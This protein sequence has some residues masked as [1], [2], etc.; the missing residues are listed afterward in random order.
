MK[1]ILL[2]SALIVA[3]VFSACEQS[4]NP[5]DTQTTSMDKATFQKTLDE[6]NPT[7]DQIA[8]MD[9]MYYLDEDMSSII[10][11]MQI[12]KLNTMIQ[13]VTPHVQDG[14][15]DRRI[16]F[17]MAA[18]LYYRLILKAIPDITDAQKQALKDLIAA[19]QQARID[20]IKNASDLDALKLELKRIHDQL[21]TDMNALLT[22]WNYYDAVQELKAKLEQQRKELHEKMV[23]LRIDWQVKILTKLLQLTDVQ[24]QQIKTLMTD[25]HAAVLLLREQFK[26]N[27]EGFRDALKALHEKTLT[28]IGALLTPE[29]LEKWKRWTSGRGGIMPGGGIGPRG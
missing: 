11:G 1:R 7:T 20:A 6:F 14:R 17:D 18:V 16:V 10:P 12:S 3:L 5:N 28:D 13:S 22:D 25:Q 23:Q 24:A 2:S 4:P 29:Q 26:D 15:F 27:P 9:E 19:A 8:F 21:V